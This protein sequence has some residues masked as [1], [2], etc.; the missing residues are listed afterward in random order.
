MTD[1][2]ADGWAV[3]H[4]PEDGTDPYI[5][6]PYPPIEQEDMESFVREQE[7]TCRRVLMPMGFPKGIK[8]MMAMDLATAIETGVM[9]PLPG[10]AG[11]VH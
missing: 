11:P 4:H 10:H 3:V 1:R 9:P 6:G 5:L 7:C 8:M 2:Y